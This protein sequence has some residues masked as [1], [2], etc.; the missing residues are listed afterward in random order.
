[1]KSSRDKKKTRHEPEGGGGEKSLLRDP[2][3]ELRLGGRENRRAKVTN[4]MG[5]K[6]RKKKKKTAYI[7]VSR[8][9]Q[10]GLYPFLTIYQVLRHMLCSSFMTI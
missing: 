4:G 3:S 10:H 7:R 1:M 5:E 8:L 2:G 9:V 6:E